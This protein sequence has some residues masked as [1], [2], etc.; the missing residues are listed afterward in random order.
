MVSSK[1][2]QRGSARTSDIKSDEKGR[3]ILSFVML[4]SQA[5]VGWDMK[6]VL[7]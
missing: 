3:K 5:L 1:F 4:N 6:Y 7:G 2:F